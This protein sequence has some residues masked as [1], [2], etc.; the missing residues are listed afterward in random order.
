MFISQ[1]IPICCYYQWYYITMNKGY[2]V[3][4]FLID[5]EWLVWK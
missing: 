1:S 5:V 2:K 3:E 4:V